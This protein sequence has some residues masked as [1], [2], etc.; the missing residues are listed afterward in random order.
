VRK[1]R[2]RRKGGIRS[3]EEEEEEEEDGEGWNNKAVTDGE[4]FSF[5]PI[6]IP[7]ADAAAAA[8]AASAAA[9]ADCCLDRLL[10]PRLGK[11]IPQYA[12]I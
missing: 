4:I 1:R 10:Q 7:I 2:S 6:L 8:G 3:N 11:Q 9:G 12:Y 5:S